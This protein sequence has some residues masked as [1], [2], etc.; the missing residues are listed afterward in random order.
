MQISSFEDTCRAAEKILSALDDR[1]ATTKSTLDTMQSDFDA[2]IE[3]VSEVVRIAISTLNKAT[4]PNKC[5]P[6]GAP[7]IGGKRVLRMRANFSNI[8]TDLR[9]QLD[10]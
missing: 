4:S 5:V 10:A 7:Y 6:A 3:E 8:N 1:I 2:C 9:K